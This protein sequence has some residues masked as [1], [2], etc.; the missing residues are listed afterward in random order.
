LL[1]VGRVGRAHG[2]AGEL[3]VDLVTDRTERVAAGAEMWANGRRLV[4]RTGR[5]HQHRWIVTFEGVS[6]REAAEALVGA[7]LEAEPIDDPDAIWVHDLIGARCVEQR[8]GVDR[9][10]V[11]A[12]IENPAHDLLE[13][14][15]GALVP[16]VFV[17][18]VA[19]GVV[20][21][22]P[23]DGLFE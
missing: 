6:S 10:E 5:K 9:G 16:I 19:S 12:V 2:L 23:P 4:V 22:D 14:A 13:L 17:V 18:D 11:V 20:T 3:Y 15:S 7:V 8:T 21:I 1:E